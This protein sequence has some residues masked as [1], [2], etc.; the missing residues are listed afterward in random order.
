MARPIAET[1][2]LHGKEADDFFARAK[3][4]ENGL[5]KISEEEKEEIK[6]SYNKLMA[7]ADFE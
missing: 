1:P 5:H 6:D 3:E 7:I 2:I 4:V